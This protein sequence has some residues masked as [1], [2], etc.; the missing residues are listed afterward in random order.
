MTG[1]DSIYQD[2]WD[3]FYIGVWTSAGLSCLVGLSYVVVWWRGR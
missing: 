2:A 1:R 3:A